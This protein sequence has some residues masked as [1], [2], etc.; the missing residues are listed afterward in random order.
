MSSLNTNI[1]HRP[2]PMHTDN[3]KRLLDL[4]R[5][6][7]DLN[8]GNLEN[9]QVK[10]V[11]EVNSNK[12]EIGE[13]QWN[14]NSKLGSMVDW[15][16]DRSQNAW[17]P[18]Y[19]KQLSVFDNHK[20]TD[21][22]MMS[23]KTAKF[24]SSGNIV[25][26]PKKRVI[27]TFDVSCHSL[28]ELMYLCASTLTSQCI[29][30]LRVLLNIIVKE[31]NKMY[32]NKLNKPILPALLESG[33]FVRLR[34]LLDSSNEQ[35]LCI[36]LDILICIAR[37][38]INEV[39]LNFLLWYREW[40]DHSVALWTLACTNV[41]LIDAKIHSK[42]SDHELSTMDVGFALLQTNTIDRCCILLSKSCNMNVKT[43]IVSLLN[44]IFNHSRYAALKILENKYILQTICN[45]CTELDADGTSMMRVGSQF[46]LNYSHCVPY[47]SENSIKFIQEHALYMISDKHNVI[48]SEDIFCNYIRIAQALS[49]TACNQS[50]MS[51][52][53]QTCNTCKYNS[54]HFVIVDYLLSCSADE[55]TFTS[56]LK[57]FQDILLNN[58]EINSESL[59]MC[60]CIL[61]RVSRL[62]NESLLLFTNI[63]E[64]IK[65][66]VLTFQMPSLNCLKDIL[67]A[68]EQLNES[69]LWN[70]K[71]VCAWFHFHTSLRRVGGDVFVQKLIDELYP[72][73]SK[74]NEMLNYLSEFQLA[75]SPE[76]NSS[77]SIVN[78]KL[79]S[80]VALYTDIVKANKILGIMSYLNWSQ[81][82]QF[83][84]L[85]IKI[86]DP[87][88]ILSQR[89]LSS[90]LSN[91]I[92]CSLQSSTMETV[93]F[94]YT[95]IINQANRDNTFDVYCKLI[96]EHDLPKISFLP[97]KHGP[98]FHI[99]N[100]CYHHYMVPLDWIYS[101][102][103]QMVKINNSLTIDQKISY[104]NTIL[105]YIFAV[106]EGDF[107]Y[108]NLISR[109]TKF[110]LIASV[111]FLGSNVFLDTQ[112][113]H[114]M[115]ALLVQMSYKL[116][117]ASELDPN[118]INA[119]TGS[120]MIFYKELLELYEQE[121]Y[122]DKLFALYLIAPICFS[123]EPLTILDALSSSL[124]FIQ[125]T[126]TVD[127]FIQV[128]GAD[129]LERC[130]MK[131]TIPSNIAV[132]FYRASLRL[133]SAAN[134]ISSRQITLIELLSCHYLNSFIYDQ[135][136]PPKDVI[137]RKSIIAYL[138]NNNGINHKDFNTIILNYKS[139]VRG[140]TS[141]GRFDESCLRS[142]I[143]NELPKNQFR[144]HQYVRFFVCKIRGKSSIYKD[145]SNGVKK[146]SKMSQKLIK[147]MIVAVIGCT[148][149]GKSK[150][151]IEIAKHF[152]GEI[153][154]ADSM[155]I[156][157][158]LPVTT[159]QPSLTDM[160]MCNHHLYSFV[161]AEEKS[162]TVRDYKNHAVNVIE[163]I[164]GRNKLPIITGGT[165]YYVES[166]LWENLIDDERSE[167][168]E[169]NDLKESE[170]E[171][172]CQVDMD[173][174]LKLHPNDKRHIKRALEVYFR[175]GVKLSELLENQHAQS[176]TQLRVELPDCSKGQ[177]MVVS[178]IVTNKLVG[179]I[180]FILGIDVIRRVG[181]V[182][183]SS[184]GITFLSSKLDGRVSLQNQN[185]TNEKVVM[186]EGKAQDK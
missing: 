34:I 178:A 59:L 98:A 171:M 25:A 81:K 111:F 64:L 110:V 141:A 11:D 31:L 83:L 13:V 164:I 179:D 10:V 19:P 142:L 23:T 90:K 104:T 177:I 68:K 38:N 182:T 52:L 16:V 175:K 50:L 138:K 60:I 72:L 35:I 123:K 167:I 120:F 2:Q 87:V 79:A 113:Y 86:A 3:E 115:M 146:C 55:T 4:Q 114:L 58:L 186:N 169:S 145:N 9:K 103:R 20:P 32:E 181:G 17:K 65:E 107:N 40:I 129:N 155:Q 51:I 184:S 172:L 156:Y 33:L 168:D 174:A 137:I 30:G 119:Y 89:V 66:K 149:V 106:E 101:V 97:E 125:P 136:V 91:M 18:T 28:D 99:D 76:L 158:S 162:F 88:S 43:K 170:Y 109:S 77:L 53:I 173:S 73:Y 6:F 154:N 82:Y 70:L 7:K 139:F 45:C 71:F 118:E 41:F 22:S 75:R 8:T 165:N 180:D 133:R 62:E 39:E 117:N 126:V 46:L 183:I 15:Q 56:S 74:R 42:I 57:I 134:D 78:A 127:D 160:S 54:V 128:L 1:Y 131:C 100:Q 61:S 159:N 63:L 95:N 130:L 12:V 161:S 49:Q 5:M 152:N 102:C 148:G 69:K 124:H 14:D 116:P 27:K 24:D 166:V 163:D 93:T 48:L 29:Y 47:L 140:E 153:V 26:K 84:Q 108:T 147:N 85:F 122:N 143:Y 121:S 44:V 21:C 67:F 150:L 94:N 80:D 105:T 157:S 185:K 176:A 135:S 144:Y 112:V 92:S 151:A 132:Q 37:S 96:F 36:I